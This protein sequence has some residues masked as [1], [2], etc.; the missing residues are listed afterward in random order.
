MSAVGTNSCLLTPDSEICIANDIQ[1]ISH[2][3]HTLYVGGSGPNNYTKIQDAINDSEDGYTIYVYYGIYN[4]SIVINKSISLIGIEENGEK[5]VIDGG[6]RNFAVN[7][8]ADGCIIK[9]FKIINYGEENG[10]YY[11]IIINS[12]NNAIENNTILS[13]Y[14]GID[15]FYSSNNTIS[16]NTISESSNCAIALC[17]Y[18]NNNTITKNDI[19]YNEWDG[20][21]LGHSCGNIISMNNVSRNAYG[22]LIFSYSDNNIISYNNVYRNKYYGISIQGGS[23]NKVIGNNVYKN[24]RWCGI[25]IVKSWSSYNLISNNTVSS[26]NWCGIQVEGIGNTISRN[27]IT[28]NSEFGISL[29]LFGSSKNNFIT[30]NNLIENGVNAYFWVRILSFNI[31]YKNYWSDWSLPIPKPIFGKILLP[32]GPFYSLILPWINFDWHPVTTPYGDG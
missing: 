21:F 2:N 28:H 8:T 5:P 14:V 3:G 1:K 4:E 11:G 30:E 13:S 29:D 32:L 20:I 19:K 25:C 7:I 18:S 12:I 22:I 17:R 15:L 23:Y 26:N 6:G 27:N 24:Q 9:S 16:R 31:W 10:R